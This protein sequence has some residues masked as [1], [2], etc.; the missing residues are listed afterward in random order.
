[1]TTIYV[2]EDVLQSWVQVPGSAIVCNFCKTTDGLVAVMVPTETLLET[3][4][5][6]EPKG[7][8]E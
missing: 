8:V 3:M 5:T 2:R 7:W 4:L 1:M 6:G